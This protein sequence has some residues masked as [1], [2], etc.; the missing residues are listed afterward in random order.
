VYGHC[1]VRVINKAQPARPPNDY[2]APRAA[3]CATTRAGTQAAT[4]SATHAATTNT[5]R[6]AAW[7]RWNFPSTDN[8]AMLQLFRNFR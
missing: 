3:M 1:G 5:M 2:A 7:V 4:A 8:S 6:R